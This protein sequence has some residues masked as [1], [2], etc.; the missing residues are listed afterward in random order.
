MPAFS[1]LDG[2]KVVPTTPTAVVTQD[3]V[4]TDSAAHER[5]KDRDEERA[6]LACRHLSMTLDEFLDEP[7]QATDDALH[8]SSEQVLYGEAMCAECGALVYESTEC[9]VCGTE[10]PVNCAK[11]FAVNEHARAVV[12]ALREKWTRPGSFSEEMRPR[13]HTRSIAASMMRWARRAHRRAQSLGFRNY[14]DR[15]EKDHDFMIDQ[16]NCG[17]TKQTAD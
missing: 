9:H 10:I 11:Q 15:F 12:E 8:R 17:R 14:A 6:V 16:L 2:R 3:A 5:Q 7:G 1:T 13:E 4:T